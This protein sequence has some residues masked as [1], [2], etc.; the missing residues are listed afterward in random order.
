MGATRKCTDNNK[1]LDIAEEF[2]VTQ[3]DMLDLAS[4]PLKKLAGLA[5]QTAEEGEKLQKTKDF[6]DAVEDASIIDV[7]E[8]RYTLS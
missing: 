3:E 1:L 7:S 6:L 4:I 2:G 5:G 8:T